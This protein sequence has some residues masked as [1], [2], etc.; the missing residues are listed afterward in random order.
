MKL[1]KLTDEQQQL[2]LAARTRRTTEL[3]A[4]Y[5]GQMTRLV[6][7]IN[8]AN[9][10]NERR[11]RASEVITARQERAFGRRQGRA[12]DDARDAPVQVGQTWREGTNIIKIAQIDGG[13]FEARSSTGATA[14]KTLEAL[15]EAFYFDYP[16]AVRVPE[17]V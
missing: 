17:G 15:S 9:A 10:A 12:K 4:I 2:V 6:E 16:C 13:L 14:A 1:S 11:Q 8:A 5:K 7:L 3:L